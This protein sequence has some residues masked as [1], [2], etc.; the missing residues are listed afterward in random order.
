MEKLDLRKELRHLYQPGAK[1]PV[2]VEV[3]PFRFLA[4]EG[5]GGV[6]GTEFQAAIGALYGLAYPLKF[7]AK[8]KR[9]LDYPVMPLEGLYWDAESGGP[10]ALGQPERL[11][12]RLLIMVPEAV[13]EEL[14]E[15][16]RAEVAAKKDPPRLAEVEL[17]TL[18]EGQSVQIMHVGPYAA[19]TATV[20]R[21]LGFAEEQ[22]LAVA[23]HHHEIY[24]SDPNRTAAER[25]KTVVRYPV[26][27]IG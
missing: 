14:I 25:L 24:I 27:P 21:L 3:P 1:A 22:G 2:L 11:A 17:Q 26:N 8:F 19:E 12:W 4:I 5:V 13:P 18:T 15:T 9:D 10:L 16:T 23:S 20:E 6:G 7:A